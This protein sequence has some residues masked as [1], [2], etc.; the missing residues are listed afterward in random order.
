MPEGRDPSPDPNWAVL[1]EEAIQI[2]RDYLRIDTTNPPG[3]ETAAAR[4]LQG[5]L[6]RE[7]IESH[8]IESAPGRGNLVARLRGNGPLRPLILHHHMDVV[9]ADRRFWSVD[10]FGG[11]VRDGYV[12]GRGALDMKGIGL[13]QLTAF[14]AVKRQGVPLKRDVALLATADEEA[15]S[16]F[17]AKFLAEQ[18][19]DLIRG[20]EYALSEWGA[21]HREPGW[22]GALGGITISEKTVLPIRL[23]A[24]GIPGHGSMPWPDTAVNRL[25]RALNRLL[26]TPRPLRVIPEVQQYFAAYGRLLPGDQGA[27]YA[28]LSVS[29][30]KPAFREEFLKSPHRAAMVRTT[31]AITVL[32]GSE[33]RNVIP[34]EAAADVDCRLLAGDDPE[35]ILNW[36]RTVIADDQVTVEAINTPKAPN[37]SSPDTELYKVMA[38]L[39]PL[40]E[41]TAVVAPQ[42]LTGFT[43]CWFFRGLG[44]AS[45]GFTPFVLDLS[46][47]SRL[48]GNDERISLENLRAGVRIYYELLL[49]I[50]AA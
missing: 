39:L 20:A 45:Y 16:T 44:V 35:E 21:I 25:I 11:E 29:F 12:W 28:D 38:E 22:R 31:F 14:L 42:V 8:L 5:I 6:E 50:A 34:P 13:L 30:Q 47:L 19:P 33:K 40:R 15:G 26:D 37:L 4:F 36:V 24:R 18:H 1:E 3:N 49:R 41:P 10:P 7:G 48:H 17:G 43:D 23:T 9:Y 2:L 27:L 46:E 32:K